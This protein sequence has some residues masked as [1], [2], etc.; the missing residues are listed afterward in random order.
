MSDRRLASDTAMLLSS[1]NRCRRPLTCTTRSLLS[2]PA[3]SS[4]LG[5]TTAKS[6]MKVWETD[7]RRRRQRQTRRLALDDGEM[8]DRTT[9]K[10]V[11]GLTESRVSLE[12]RKG[13][14][15]FAPKI[16]F[17]LVNPFFGKS[18]SQQDFP[19]CHPQRSGMNTYALAK[20]NYC[21]EER[22]SGFHLPLH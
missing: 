13:L 6:P 16:K 2:S 3:A 10:G 5:S 22:V 18:A 15:S 19:K 20:C 7:E 14:C 9:R 1:I 21:G 17:A 4:Q 8:R 12:W 11:S